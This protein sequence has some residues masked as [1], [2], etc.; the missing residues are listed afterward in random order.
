MINTE[1]LRNTITAGAGNFIVRSAYTNLAGIG[2][3]DMPGCL[4]SGLI[5][6]SNAVTSTNSIFSTNGLNG[7]SA[8]VIEQ[9]RAYWTPTF[10][11]PGFLI[12]DNSPPLP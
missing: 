4:L 6:R 1:V 7:I 5:F 9:N 3:L 12:Q 2:I 8:N 11:I 10:A